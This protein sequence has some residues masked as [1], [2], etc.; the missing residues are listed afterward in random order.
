MLVVINEVRA[1]T[2]LYSPRRGSEG[3]DEGRGSNDTGR[4]IRYTNPTCTSAKGENDGM[5]EVDSILWK[6][7]PR[8]EEMLSPRVGGGLG[9]ATRVSGGKNTKFESKPAMRSCC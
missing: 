3:S 4:F 9:A 6:D 5:E 7:G 8:R 2:C 1:A